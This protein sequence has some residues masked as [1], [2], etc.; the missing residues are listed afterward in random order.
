MCGV[1]KS[2]RKWRD[3]LNA[4]ITESRAM[5][6]VDILDMIRMGNIHG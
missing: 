5:P 6:R 3:W 2:L 4:A 1:E